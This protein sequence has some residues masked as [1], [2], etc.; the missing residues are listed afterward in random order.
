VA[1]IPLKVAWPLV[2]CLAAASAAGDDA[3]VSSAPCYSEAGIV[4]AA[5]FMRGALS[6]NTIVAIFG[7]NLSYSTRALVPDDVQGG[8]LPLQLAGVTVHIGPELAP[9][10][11]VSPTQINALI[12][13]NLKTGNYE[14]RVVRDGW[15]GRGAVITLADSSPAL[16]LMD[17]TSAVA[18]HPDFSVVTPGSPARPGSFVILWATGL[19]PVVP[20][21]AAYAQL[22]VKL[23]WIERL[24]GFKVLLN[25]VPVEANRIGYAGIAPYLAGVY[26]INVNLP[27]SLDRDPEVAL[28]LGDAVSPRGVRLAVGVKD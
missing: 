14:V 13:G 3:C 19:G 18:S 25:G 16:F 5:S 23:A 15:S 21:P 24:A 26:Q 6:P 9:L 7:S 2:V 27:E 12:P 28:S 1:Y 10:Y 8:K 22:P 20:P 11:F 17:S 4:N